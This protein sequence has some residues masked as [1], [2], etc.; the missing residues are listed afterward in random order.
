MGIIPCWM[1][2]DNL[3][4]FKSQFSPDRAPFFTYRFVHDQGVYRQINELKKEYDENVHAMSYDVLGSLA[5]SEYFPLYR[6]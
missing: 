3:F 4:H 6:G 2:F 1:E 5:K